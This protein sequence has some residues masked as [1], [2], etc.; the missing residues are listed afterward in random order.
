VERP[1]IEV[2]AAKHWDGP[3]HPS[4]NRVS[5]C[6]KDFWYFDSTV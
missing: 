2:P 4:M 5:R 6:D 1:P 3:E